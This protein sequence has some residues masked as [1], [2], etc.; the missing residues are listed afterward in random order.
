MVELTRIV[1]DAIRVVETMR[2]EAVV[3]IRPIIRAIRPVARMATDSPAF[4]IFFIFIY[5]L[6]KFYCAEVL[7]L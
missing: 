2:A 4:L 1:V 6:E 7:R 5:F 3:A